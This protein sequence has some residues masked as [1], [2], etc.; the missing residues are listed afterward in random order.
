MRVH[1]HKSRS[2]RVGVW[3]HQVDMSLSWEREASE[4]LVQSRHNRG[5]L[6]SY[7]LAPKTGNL[8]FEEVVTRVLQEN[9]EIH[10]RA[11]ERFRSMLNSSHRQWARLSQELDKLSQG[12]EAAM[13]R[14]LRK[15]TEE[16][17]GVLQTALKK[18]E[19]LMAESEDH[20]EE[21]QMREEEAHPEDQGQSDSSEGQDGDVVVEG[22]EGSGLTGAEAIDPLRSQEAEPSMEVDVRDILLL[23]SKDA[24]TVTPEEDDMLTGNPTSVAGDMAWLQVA[25]PDS[26]KPEDGKTL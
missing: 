1:D 9:W 24:T 10:E 25:S 26:H 16:R 22:A 4:S 23:T 8:C 2:L 6:L 3:L 19:A 18:V 21:S 5:P 14:K 15:Q 20:L 7:L 13:D 17:M 11:K 12:I